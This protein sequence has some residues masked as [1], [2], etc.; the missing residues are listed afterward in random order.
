METI[1]RHGLLSGDVNLTKAKAQHIDRVAYIRRGAYTSEVTF[2][3]DR[4]VGCEIWRFTQYE[5]VDKHF[6]TSCIG[7]GKVGVGW[8]VE[9]CG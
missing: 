9:V 3:F 1:L 7:D 5:P 6:T 8:I 2:R 4:E